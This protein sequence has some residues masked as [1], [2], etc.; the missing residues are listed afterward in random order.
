[1]YPSR[2]IY[3]SDGARVPWS[4]R[5]FSVAVLWFCSRKGEKGWRVEGGGRRQN[6]TCQMTYVNELLGFMSLIGYIG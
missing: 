2:V 4:A 3:K 5:L 1:M 6:F